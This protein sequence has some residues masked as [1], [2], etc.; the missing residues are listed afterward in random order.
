MLHIKECIVV[1]GAYDKI[2][3]SQI[4][5]GAIFVTHGFS[6]FNKKKDIE[7]LKT[8]AEKCG[9][10]ILT[11][12]DAAGFKI[13]NYIKQALPKDKVKHAYIPAVKGKER[14]KD[15][16]GKEGLLGV[17]GI[18]DDIIIS[19]LKNAGCTIN[20]QSNTAAKEQITKTD[21]YLAGLSGGSDSAD[22][23]RRLCSLIE[24]PG[25]ISA[26][27]LVDSI[28]AIMSK[29]EFFDIIENI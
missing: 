11:D 1:E 2:K 5:D 13:R 22:K 7:T 9:V 26:N 29:D 17:E 10:V 20:G 25:R 27:M 16:P 24:L 23:R 3:L 19:A 6:I 4:V 15:K 18:S 28:N 21:L 8:F 14:R 12:S